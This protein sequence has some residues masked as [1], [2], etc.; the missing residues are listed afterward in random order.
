[1]AVFGPPG[2]V[3]EEGRPVEAPTLGEFTGEAGRGEDCD[4]LSVYSL[5]LP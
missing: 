2:G 1:M 5:T 3:G 4:C